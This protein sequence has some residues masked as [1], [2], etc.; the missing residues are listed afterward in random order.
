VEQTLAANGAAKI[1]IVEPP[2]VFDPGKSA[3]LANVLHRRGYSS[4]PPNLDFLLVVD[5]QPLWE[6][7]KPSR[8]QRINRCRR[9]GMTVSRVGQEAYRQAYDVIVE[10]RKARGFPVTM[11]FESIQQMIEAFPGKLT[12]FGVFKS[13]SMIAASICMNINP[14]VFYVFYWGDLPGYERFSPVSLLAEVIYAHAREQGF[15]LIDF[16]TSTKD[17]VPIYGLINFKK[18][19]GCFPSLKPAYTK[20]IAGAAITAPS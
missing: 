9:D 6:K 11:S 8:R 14:S 7:L 4:G 10:N 18:E 17:G 13:N 15:G 3:L 5:E 2:M 16:G 20:M 12:F 1:E 19:I